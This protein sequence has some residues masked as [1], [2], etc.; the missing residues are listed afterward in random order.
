MASN[1]EKELDIKKDLMAA[2]RPA[3][4]AKANAPD[5]KIVTNKMIE[6]LSQPVQ[7]EVPDQV[8][9]SLQ[10]RANAL[11]EKK[12]KKSI[13]ET[14]FSLKYATAAMASVLVAVVSIVLLSGRENTLEPQQLVYKPQVIKKGTR[15]VSTG[16]AMQAL[17][18]GEAFFSEGKQQ[19][20]Y[21]KAGIWK[22]DTQHQLLE[23]PVW[24]HFPGG[25]IQPVGT[26]FTI[27]IKPSQTQIHLTEGKLN[28][29]RTQGNKRVFERIERPAEISVAKAGDMPPVQEDIEY[30]PETKKAEILQPVKQ[31]GKYQFFLNKNISVSLNSGDRISGKLVKDTAKVIY[32][33][34][35][36]G[37]MTIPY[38]EIKALNEK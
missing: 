4:P 5:Q 1:D 7:R 25:G 16:L 20:Y 21:L 11:T 13:L 6:N 30:M 32:L 36:S 38:R 24:F 17:D 14:I 10:T 8:W 27:E 37:Q 2:L 29:Y 33:M 19:N 35:D 31:S 12:Q 23:K 26:K 34:T 3:E 18:G 22:I 9:R 15:I 28:V